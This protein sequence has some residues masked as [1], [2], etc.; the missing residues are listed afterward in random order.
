MISLMSLIFNFKY[1]VCRSFRHISK[2][3]IFPFYWESSRQQIILNYILKYFVQLL[4][5]FLYYS[6]VYL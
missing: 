4:L 6:H 1:L 3:Q 2:L 5:S